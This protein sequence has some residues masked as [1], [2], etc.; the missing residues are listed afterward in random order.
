MS[1]NT[2]RGFYLSPQNI[3]TVPLSFVDYPFDLDTS[4]QAFIVQL[5]LYLLQPP[6]CDVNL[7]VNC[8]SNQCHVMTL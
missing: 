5:Q 2:T 3:V 6:G 4:Q 7:W 1:T 8:V